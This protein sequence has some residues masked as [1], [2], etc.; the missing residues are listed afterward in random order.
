[1]VV[2][3]IDTVGIAVHADTSADGVFFF[4]IIN[5]VVV[6]TGGNTGTTVASGCSGA[7]AGSTIELSVA[8][9]TYT[10]YVNGSAVC[11]GTFSTY[12][13]GRPAIHIDNGGGSSAGLTTLRQATSLR[14]W[15]RRPSLQARRR[16]S[17]LSPWRS[18]FRGATGC[19][20]TDG[21]TPNATI[22]GTCSHGSTYSSGLSL[23]STTTVKAIATKVGQVKSSV[24][25]VTYTLHTPTNWYVDP[26]NGGPR[27]SAASSPDVSNSCN[28]SSP[29]A[30]NPSSGKNQNCPYNTVE[31]LWNDPCVAADA[32]YVMLSGDVAIIT[33]CSQS[34]TTGC[35]IAGAT[36]AAA[37]GNPCWGI[38]VH[39]RGRR[40]LHLPKRLQRQP[41]S[42]S[43]KH[44]CI[45]P[46]PRS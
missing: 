35:E 20:T 2:K 4:P 14:H 36:S 3:S 21:S 26:L 9:N 32:N 28:G 37:P 42:Q 5:S 38:G 25:T 11:S 23:S 41:S 13:T 30:F 10:V 19:Y 12:T 43:S 22:P 34:Q 46:F 29:A 17:G 18:R 33:N 7:T 31:Q 6:R 27:Y 44:G 15:S 39:R 1:V 8:G 16:L 45:G 24:A 40:H